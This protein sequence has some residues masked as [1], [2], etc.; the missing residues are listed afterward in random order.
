MF[1]EKIKQIYYIN[2]A[3][4]KLRRQKIKIV[5]ITGSYGKTSCK[6]Y[7]YQLINKQFNVLVTPKSYNTLNGI[8][9]SINKLL[10][11]FHEVLI[12]EIGVDEKNAMNKYLKH[13]SFD[14]CV[15]TCIGNQHIKTFKTIENI[16]K[17]K[18]KLL[19]AAKETIILNKDDDNLKDLLFDKQTITCSAN[20]NNA[21]IFVKQENDLLNIKI[22]D[23]FYTTKSSLIGIHNICNLALCIGVS[24]AIN[25]SNDVIINAIS[26]LKN[27]DHRLSIKKDGK[28]TIIDDS[29]NSNYV[30]FKNALNVLKAYPCYKVLIT[31]G[32]IEQSKNNNEDK[33]LAKVI[34]ENCDLVILINNPSISN[35]IENKLSF[36]HFIEAYTYL[37][38][39]YLDK[40]MVILI[41][42]DVPDIYLK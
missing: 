34:E 7:I 17:E 14:V 22:Y 4:E 31:P 16:K 42:N 9:I 27:V 20:N 15:V 6:N 3:K 33:N 40:E 35:Y 19:Y 28:W 10:K 38:G 32:V 41:E 24:K 25:T 18:T 5:A 23:N 30:G 12:V 13:F 36:T 37:K 39:N 8:L 29:Y 26:H 21:D 2:K 1:L 11:P